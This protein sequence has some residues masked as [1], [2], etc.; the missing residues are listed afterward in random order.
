MAHLKMVQVGTDVH[1]N[2]VYNVVDENDKLVKTTIFTEAEALAMISGVEV[3]AA[4]VEEAEVIEEVE[5]VATPEPE[6][7]RDVPDYGSMTKAQLEALMREHGIELDRRKSKGDL[8]E[9]VDGYFKGYF[10]I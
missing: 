9:Q 5:E 3:E 7:S 4:P 8:L 10:N 6:N 1:D 2:P